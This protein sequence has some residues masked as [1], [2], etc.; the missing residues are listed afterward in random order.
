[1]ASVETENRRNLVDSLRLQGLTGYAISKKLK[2]PMRTVYGDI[3]FLEKEEERLSFLVVREQKRLE[4]D[5]QLQAQMAEAAQNMAKALRRVKKTKKKTTRFPNNLEE[6]ETTEETY[7]PH[8]NAAIG[9]QRNYLDALARRA[10]LWGVEQVKQ[11]VA[12]TGLEM[13]LTS[14]SEA[15][16]E[17]PQENRCSEADSSISNN[18]NNQG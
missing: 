1:M 18:R 17:K 12:V 14:L 5:K 16:N 9:F 2:I 6:V 4:I 15:A 7:L 3:A 11:E 10:A 13:L 8:Y